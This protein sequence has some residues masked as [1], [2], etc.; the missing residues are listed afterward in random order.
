[1]SSQLDLQ[2][3]RLPPLIL[4]HLRSWAARALSRLLRSQ[5]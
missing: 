2:L 4:A 1:M 3:P 5:L